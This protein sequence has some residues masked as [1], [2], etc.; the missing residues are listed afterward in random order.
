MVTTVR[1]SHQQDMSQVGTPT[2]DNI[3][4]LSSYS[5]D[6]TSYIP[7]NPTLRPNDIGVLA[8]GHQTI[9][10]EGG[11]KVTILHKNSQANL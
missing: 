7:T 2:H 4:I 3:N 5:S 10:Q 11:M 6:R 8:S 1:G 9:K